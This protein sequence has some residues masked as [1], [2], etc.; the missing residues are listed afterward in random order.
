MILFKEEL[1]KTKKTK[2]NKQKKTKK[3]NKKQKTFCGARRA[4]FFCLGD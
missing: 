1:R 2:T 3:K 4:F